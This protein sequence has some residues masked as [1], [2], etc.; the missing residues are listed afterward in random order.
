[1]SYLGFNKLKE[2]IAKSGAKNPAAVASVIGRKKYGEKKF[3]KAAHEGKSM[4]NMEPKK[5]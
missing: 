1:M 3:E 2:K 5:K 4:K